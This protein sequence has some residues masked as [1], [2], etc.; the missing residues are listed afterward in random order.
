MGLVTKNAG[1][2]RLEQNSSGSDHEENRGTIAP[3]RQSEAYQPESLKLIS[4]F[5]NCSHGL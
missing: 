2:S 1:T 3:N 4:E 5:I